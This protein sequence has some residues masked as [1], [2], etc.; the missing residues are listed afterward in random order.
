LAELRQ[1]RDVG[2]AIIDVVGRAEDL[3]ELGPKMRQTIAGAWEA[4]NL[5]GMREVVRDLRGMLAALPPQ[6]R[7]AVSQELERTAGPALGNLDV[8]DKT[9]IEAALHRGLIRNDREYFLLRSH[10]ERLESDPARVAEVDSVVRLL[11]SYRV[12]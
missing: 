3:G 4:Q 5:R 9:A 2:L 10:L 12:S 8:T 6:A 1:L 11:E 7:K